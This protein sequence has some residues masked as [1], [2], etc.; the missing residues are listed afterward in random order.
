MPLS[1]SHFTLR[2]RENGRSLH[3]PPLRCPF[4]S[5]FC[6][7]SSVPARVSDQKGLEPAAA[8]VSAAAQRRVAPGYRRWRLRLGTAHP[9]S[10]TPRR[11]L[12]AK[13]VPFRGNRTE[14]AT[15]NQTEDAV[16][17]FGERLGKPAIGLVYYSGH[18]MQ[19]AGKNPA[20]PIRCLNHR[21]RG[22]RFTFSMS[23]WC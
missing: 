22:G 11:W 16:V 5:S 6:A 23:N 18:G 13:R 8:A 21:S 19:L 2:E 10:T 14:S 1:Q 20:F 7:I 9:P 3:H 4:T 12:G 17:M 15:K